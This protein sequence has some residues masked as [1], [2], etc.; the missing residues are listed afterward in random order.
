MQCQENPQTLQ[1]CAS[2]K[3]LDTRQP[4][5][6]TSTSA[7]NPPA[8][9]RQARAN[10]QEPVRSCAS[11][12]TPEQV[13]LDIYICQGVSRAH[14]NRK[15]INLVT[16]YRCCV[17]SPPARGQQSLHPAISGA[18]TTLP[19]PTAWPPIHR[20][21]WPALPYLASE[22]KVQTTQACFSER[23]SSR[24]GSL[25]SRAAG[26][27]GPGLRTRT[28]S[29]AERAAACAGVRNQGLGRWTC[30]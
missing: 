14:S 26:A 30:C 12:Y 2:S 24:D 6:P 7:L 9:H 22:S 11:R 20:S 1:P 3:E 18:G 23:F 21:G 8:Q 25:R 10:Q 16:R 19:C 13:H 15:G 5:L 28:D 27:A 4:R 29:D 17:R